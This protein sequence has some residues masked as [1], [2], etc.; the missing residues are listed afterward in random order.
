MASD[1]YL[2]CGNLTGPPSQGGRIQPRKVPS[3]CVMLRGGTSLSLEHAVAFTSGR[4]R[5][6]PALQPSSNATPCPCRMTL[7]ANHEGR[8]TEHRGL[9]PA[10]SACTALTLEQAPT[11]ASR[12]S[13]SASNGSTN[14][15]CPLG[16]ESTD[17]QRPCLP[18]LNRKFTHVMMGD[19]HLDCRSRMVDTWRDQNTHWLMQSHQW[20]CGRPRPTHMLMRPRPITL[21]Q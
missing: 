18:D 3:T 5:T 15:S 13:I 8:A 11:E 20:A 7:K 12:Q 21:L 1:E 19:V 14:Q 16:V 2:T 10:L 9:T 4:V 17:S 6:H